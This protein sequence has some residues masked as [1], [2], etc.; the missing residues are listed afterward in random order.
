MGPAGSP[1]DLI[2]TVKSRYFHEVIDAMFDVR[3][4]GRYVKQP[5]KNDLPLHVDKYTDR[6]YRHL[7]K[8]CVG[9]ID[10]TQ[11]IAT[12]P[13]GDSARCRN[14]AKYLSF[15][16]LACIGLDGLFTFILA[17]W[18][19]SDHDSNVYR[20]AVE[21]GLKIPNN[22]HLLADAATD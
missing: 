17:G 7:T 19:G 12:P 6:K 3:F 13:S 21:R 4:Y 20:A 11:I 18:E 1:D 10:G 5:T 22:H 9:A 14:R 15:N 8:R 16:V 2:N